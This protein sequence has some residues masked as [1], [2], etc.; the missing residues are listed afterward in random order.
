MEQT[1]TLVL[2][3]P[4]VTLPADV[5]PT[6][7]AYELPLPSEAEYAQVIDWVIG[8]VAWRDGTQVDT[9]GLDKAELIRALSG[10]TLAQ[11]RQAV[12]YAALN[13]RRLG[14]EDIAGIIESEGEDDQGDGLLEFF[15]ADGGPELGG[16]GGLKAWLENARTGSLRKAEAFNLARAEGRADRRRAGLRQVA[17][18]EVHRARVALPLLKLDAG[19][20]YDKYVG[21]SEKNFRRAIALAEAM[22]PVVLWIDEIE[23]AFALGRAATPTAALS[24]RLFGSFLT[25]LQEKKD[26]VFVVAT[27]NDLERAAAGAAA[28][29]PLRRDLLR[30]SARARRARMQIFSIHLRAHKQDPA[31]FDLPPARFRRS[32]GF[33]GAEI[34][35]A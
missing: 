26:E 2:S 16:F 7:I 9:S 13:N 15:P 3:G 11:A 17:G 8:S 25:W 22:A 35:Q 19:R 27:A 10:M 28:Q 5:A 31:Q 1:T 21:E 34:E 32:E 18:G 6:A 23:K 24:Q 29:G 14:D 33:S 20:L 12:A 30:R 4:D